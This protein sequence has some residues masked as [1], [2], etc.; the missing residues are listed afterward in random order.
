MQRL[1]YSEADVP[2]RIYV[3][4]PP[5]RFLVGAVGRPGHRTFYLQARRGDVLV[6]VGLEKAQVAV[7]GDRIG[8]LLEA[9]R[10]AGLAGAP[11]RPERGSKQLST[12]PSGADAPSL[13]EPVDEAFRV[14]TITLGWNPEDRVV[15]VEAREE[16]ESEEEDEVD[17]DAAEGPDIVRVR[18]S[19]ED[20]SA[21]A[22][23]ALQVV[24]AG[25]PP[26]PVCGEPLN[27]EGHLCA[28]RNGFVH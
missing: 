21:F 5:D 3:F 28:R 15:V 26:C 27:P 4:D 23:H 11:E 8:A 17:D 2:R 13:E 25:R 16:V 20:A 7:V 10:R 1:R 24:A 6:T 14:G 18:V 12:P 19:A 22:E 9:V